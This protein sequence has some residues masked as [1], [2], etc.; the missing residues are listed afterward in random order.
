MLLA[1]SVR[2]VA[3][4]QSLC[5]GATV[6]GLDLGV[7]GLEQGLRGLATAGEPSSQIPKRPITPWQAFF[8][9][10]FPKYS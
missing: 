9:S 8:T 2:L 4:Q 10:K 6:R 1:S 5:Q 3:G 7:R